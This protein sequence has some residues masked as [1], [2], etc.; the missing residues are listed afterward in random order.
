MS[1]KLI[2]AETDDGVLVNGANLGPQKIVFP[3]FQVEKKVIVPKIE[4]R[5]EENKNNKEKNLK[6]VNEFNQRL[7]HE[8]QKAK[9]EG[10]FPIIIGGDH[11]ISIA[12]SL[13]SISQE[14]KLGLLWIDAHGDFNTFD[15]TITG[16]IHGLPFA[17]ITGQNGNRLT[18]FHQGNYY[19]PKNC[20]LIG[21]RDLDPLE[22]ENLKHAGITIITTNEIKENNISKI[23]EQAFQIALSSQDKVHISYDFDVIDPT[24]CMG[25]SVPA[26][27]GINLEAAK[28]ILN[29][30]LKRK[31]NIASFDL[32]ELNPTKD[33]D[34]KS[35][36][37][38]KNFLNEVITTF[39][40]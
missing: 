27:D 36:T 22:K 39:K 26:K 19:N 35:L 3:D 40:K 24:I 15:T 38:A 34:D 16:N 12:S 2:L 8:V 33:S 23:M 21:A 29:E 18:L 37:I 30:I 10:D 28:E 7:Y 17:T 4:H 13:A 14:E 6:W 32:V 5:K 25:V 9:Q 20:V 1:I 11:S 31:E